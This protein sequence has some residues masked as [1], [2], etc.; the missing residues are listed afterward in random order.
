MTKSILAILI[1]FIQSGLFAQDIST[2]E[3]SEP[4]VAYLLE[5]KWHVL[6]H[7]GQ[8]MFEPIPLIHLFGYSEG[9]FAARAFDP[10]GQAKSVFFDTHAEV[11]IV[12]DAEIIDPFKNGMAIVADQTDNQDLPF[13]AGYINK[14][15]AVILP[16]EY[17]DFTTFNDGLA[18]VMDTLAKDGWRGYVDTAGRKI[19]TLPKHVVGYKFS[20]GLAAVADSVPNVGYIN[21]K[22]DYI[23]PP[24]FDSPGE[25]SEGLIATSDSGFLGYIDVEQKKFVI[26]P[27]FDVANPFREGRAWVGKLSRD[28]HLK[29][30]LIDTEGNFLKSYLFDYVTDFSEGYASAMIN[31]KFVYVDKEGEFPFGKIFTYCAPFKNGLAW[32][33]NR[34][35]NKL[36]YIN[37]DG[38][39]IIEVPIAEKYIDLRTNAELGI[40]AV[41]DLKEMEQEDGE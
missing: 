20:D 35:E 34:D 26:D 22:G 10:E 24:I 19:I 31:N 38:E 37:T 11:R 36:G 7:S 4:L 18:Y 12:S 6:D 15:G 23:I 14:D 41:V 32:A 5:G 3:R 27:E 8:Q 13:R 39:W 29:Y 1:L 28:G 33:A 40:S 17:V 16:R 25:H 30:A 21:T 2:E 9:Y